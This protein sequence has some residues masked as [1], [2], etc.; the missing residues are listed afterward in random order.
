VVDAAGRVTLVSTEPN[1]DVVTVTETASGSAGFG[2]RTEL[3]DGAAGDPVV[4]LD[5][6]MKVTYFVR[7]ADNRLVHGWQDEPAGSWA[8]QT[9]VLADDAAGDPAVSLDA[10][11]RLTLFV[12]TTG[13]QLLHRW[14]QTPGGAWSPERVTLYGDLGGDPVVQLDA[15]RRLGLFVR[16]ND[17]LLIHKWQV[18]PGAGWSPAV[19][20]LARNVAPGTAPAP[21]VDATGR[22]RALTTTTYGYVDDSYQK[23]PSGDYSRTLVLGTIYS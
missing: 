4:A 13:N 19:G 12:R 2:P 14:Q 6:T 21:A 18:A 11:G 10:G 16:R 8:P 17:G 15:G 1:G 22:L 20:F 5:N 23:E 9:A 3:T 7:R